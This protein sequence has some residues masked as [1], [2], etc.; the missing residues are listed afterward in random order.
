MATRAIT[1]TV[2]T[3]EVT[4]TSTDIT[5]QLDSYVAKAAIDNISA[6]WVSLNPAVTTAVE[7]DDHVSID[8]GEAV[9]L[10]GLP[11]R[12]IAATAG[13]KLTIGPV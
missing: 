2:G 8:P 1:K 12:A 9:A 3:S 5:G 13:N 10:G 11:V 7:G 4:F 6:I